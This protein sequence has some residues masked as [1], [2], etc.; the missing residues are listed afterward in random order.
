[1]T[2]Q[3]TIKKLIEMHL[4]AMAQGF[5]DQLQDKNINAISF[6]DRLGILVDREWTNRKNNRLIRIIKAAGLKFSNASMEDIDYL[7]D[8][9]LDKSLL[10]KLSTCNYING[11]YNIIIVGA[12]GSGKSYLACALGISACRSFYPV[13]YIRLPDLLDELKIARGEGNFKKVVKQY[14][15]I[16]VLILD[17]WL[18]TPLINTEAAD[19]LEIVEARLQHASTIFCSQFEPEGWHDKIGQTTLADAILDRIVHNAYD[20]SIAGKMSMRERNGLKKNKKI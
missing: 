1:M 20:I 18:L 14:K 4:N 12:S 3:E 10:T 17:E 9:Q 7:P 13:K 5:M 6:E 2:D 15:Q 11:N 8:R 19:L 16:K